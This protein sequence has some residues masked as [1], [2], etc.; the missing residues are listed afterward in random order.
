MR[1]IS[2]ALPICLLLLAGCSDDPDGSDEADD[3]SAAAQAVM[4]DLGAALADPAHGFAKIVFTNIEGPDAAERYDEIVAGMDGIE[5]VIDAGSVDVDS[6]SGSG[7]ATLT[8]SWPVVASSDPWVYETTV[9]LARD[10]DEW[11]VEWAPSIVEPSLGRHEVL[12]ATTIS[13]D[14]GDM[15]GA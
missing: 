3:G 4:A 14:R 11:L 8:W 9:E 12:D 5:P 10:G 7:S 1:R 13:A 6:G 15:L 2:V